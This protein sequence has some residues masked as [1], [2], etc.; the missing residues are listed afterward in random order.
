MEQQE[1]S[2]IACMCAKSL[3]LC[4]SLCKPMKPIRMLCP[5]DYPDKNTGVGR[6]FLLQGIFLTQG[7]NPCLLCLLHWQMGSLSPVPPRKSH[8]ILA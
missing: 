7:L 5:W 3:Q 4:P 6:H 1:L 8:T 2:Y